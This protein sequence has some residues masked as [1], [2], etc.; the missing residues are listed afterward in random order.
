MLVR[1]AG[2]AQRARDEYEKRRGSN[3]KFL[4][5]KRFS[6]MQRYLGSQ[7]YAVEVGCGAG[8]SE[9]FLRAGTL[10]LT[11]AEPAKIPFHHFHLCVSGTDARRTLA[12][13]RIH[14]GRRPHTMRVTPMIASAAA[15]DHAIADTSGAAKSVPD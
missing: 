1:Y 15:V 2:D 7:T 10:E 12:E 14:A 8:F 3:L 13:H 5:R 4:L 6:W 11:D 9:L